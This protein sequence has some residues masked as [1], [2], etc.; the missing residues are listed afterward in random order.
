MKVRALSLPGVLLVSM[1]RF[2]DD[3]GYFTESYNQKVFRQAGITAEFVQDNQSFSARAGT[4]RG[5]HFQVPP[6]PQAKLV[7]VLQGRI[8]DVAVDLRRGS[9]AY[10]RWV[11][12]TLTAGGGEQ[13]FIPRGFAH[14]FCTLDPDTVVAY[15]VDGFYARACEGG[16][17][18]ND[19]TLAITWPVGAQEVVLSARDR[20]FPSFENFET[21]FGYDDHVG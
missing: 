10:G 2:P 21:P 4:I 19:P 16:I 15:K 5:L 18:W 1:P 17:I 11:G 14:G 13:L 3:R 9:P 7:R 12:E 20:T 8:Y 6:A